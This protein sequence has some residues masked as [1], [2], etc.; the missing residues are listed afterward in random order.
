MRPNTHLG[1]LLP[2]ALHAITQPTCGRR[3]G[4]EHRQKEEE[5]MGAWTEPLVVSGTACIEDGNNRRGQHESSTMVNFFRRWRNNSGGAQVT[6]RRWWSLLISLL[7]GETCPIEITANRSA[8]SFTIKI[9]PQAQ[10]DNTALKSNCLP[11]ETSPLK[12][13]I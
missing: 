13:V 6:A 7:G 5:A 9:C 3:S 8:H 2:A 11:P 4:H 10:A 1:S 12:R